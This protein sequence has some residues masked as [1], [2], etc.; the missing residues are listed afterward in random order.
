M[1]NSLVN[2]LIYGAF[3][4]CPLSKKNSKYG[5]YGLTRDNSQRSPSLMTAVTQIDCNGRQIRTFRQTSCYRSNSQNNPKEQIT[6]LQSGLVDKNSPN[7]RHMP[8]HK[9]SNGLAGGGGSSSGNGGTV[10]N[11]SKSITLNYNGVALST[12]SG[13]AT[14]NISSVWRFEGSD[15]NQRWKSRSVTNLIDKL[16]SLSLKAMKTCYVNMLL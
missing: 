4:L 7:N 15:I 11:N 6:L 10:N 12:T 5:Q 9:S 16:R 3:H 2:P 1:S 8:R 13:I 14:E